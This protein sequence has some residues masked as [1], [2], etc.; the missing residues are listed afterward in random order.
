MA[1]SQCRPRFGHTG[2]Y[3]T[4]F[5][6]MQYFFSPFS[7]DSYPYS[8]FPPQGRI[9]SR[10]KSPEPPAHSAAPARGRV[11]SGEW[12]VEISFSEVL[13]HL[14]PSV[15]HPERAKRVEGSVPLHRPHHTQGRSYRRKRILRRIPFRFAPFH[16]LRMTCGAIDN[17]ALSSGRLLAGASSR[18]TVRIQ[19]SAFSIQRSVPGGFWREQ[20]SALR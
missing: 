6:E 17:S 10:Q 12:R 9:A 7:K 14:R 13:P 16:L 20:E 3:S 18:P 4:V 2:Y 8:R 11:K 19:S 1:T 15:C 5:P